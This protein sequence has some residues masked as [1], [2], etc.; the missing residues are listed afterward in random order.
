MASILDSAVGS[1]TRNLTKETS[2]KASLTPFQNI[3][4]YDSKNELIYQILLI[5]G[6]MRLEDTESLFLRNP[7]DLFIAEQIAARLME[8][9]TAQK[10]QAS[11]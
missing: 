10:A 1:S 3:K 9:G 4:T 5:Q 6:K 11:A 8:K 2:E 7:Q